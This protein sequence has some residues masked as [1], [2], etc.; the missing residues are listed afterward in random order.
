MHCVSTVGAATHVSFLSIYFL[1]VTPFI[2]QKPVG[3]YGING[4][5][6]VAIHLPQAMPGA[7]IC[8]PFRL[9]M[10]LS[11]KRIAIMIHHYS[12]V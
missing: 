4:M 2:P 12:S 1:I 6:G 5:G 3:F 9:E 8:Q 10:Q 11:A 7:E